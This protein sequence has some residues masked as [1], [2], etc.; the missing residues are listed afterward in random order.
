[1]PTVLKQVN[2]P[3][4]KGMMLAVDRI[5]PVSCG[6]RKDMLNVYGPSG[7]GKTTF[8]V[9]YPKPLLIIGAEDGTRS[10]HNVPGVDFVKLLTT[11]ELKELLDH[12]RRTSNYATV[13]IDTATSL[14]ALDLKEV[15][16]LDELPTQKSWG[17]VSREQY[18]QS[19]LRTKEMLREVLRLAEDSICHV[20]ILAQERMHG[21]REDTGISMSELG[22]TPNI[23]SSLTKSTASWLNPECDY[24]MRSFKRAQVVEKHIKVAGKDQVTRVKTGK[25]EYC[26]LIGDHEIYITKFRKPKGVKLPEVLVDPTFEKIQELIRQGA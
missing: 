22:V 18:G 12:A 19:A 16:G 7:S 25:I 17:M 10:V 13:V 14:Q 8:A 15:L 5:A 6:T 1:M 21:D 23:C 24:I 2:K 4:V 26:M 20:L 3:V 11:T 9:S